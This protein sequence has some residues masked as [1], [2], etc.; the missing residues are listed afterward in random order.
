MRTL[1]IYALTLALAG[2][3]WAINL[4][5]RGVDPAALSQSEKDEWNERYRQD[6]AVCWEKGAAYQTY[7]GS[8]YYYEGT[9]GGSGRSSFN[10]GVYVTCMEARGYEYVGRSPTFFGQKVGNLPW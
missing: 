3:G 1:W 4:K 2:C 5:P 8:S 7:S 10:K 6:N 9:G